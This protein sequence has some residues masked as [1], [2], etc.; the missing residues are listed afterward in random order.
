MS[1]SIPFEVSGIG[2]AIPRDFKARHDKRI[3]NDMTILFSARGSHH[4]LPP[5]R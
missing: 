2:D 5:S 3:R 4:A 1:Y